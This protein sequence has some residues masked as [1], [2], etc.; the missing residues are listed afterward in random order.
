MILAATF[1]TM[2]RLWIYLR[3]GDRTAQRISSS[4]RRSAPY[5]SR[6]P[7]QP[8]NSDNTPTSDDNIPLKGGYKELQDGKKGR[9][10][11]ELEMQILKTETYEVSSRIKDTPGVA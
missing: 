11:E 4:E 10:K 1:P 7:R 3:T 2:P 5:S 8:M 6:K 9:R